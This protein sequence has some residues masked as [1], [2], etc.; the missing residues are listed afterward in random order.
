M[1]GYNYGHGPPR[2]QGGGYNQG[3]PRHQ[4]GYNQGPPRFGGGPPGPPPCPPPNRHPGRVTIQQKSMPIFFL[5]YANFF[6]SF[7]SGMIS[8]RKKRK[9][10]V[11]LSFFFQCGAIYDSFFKAIFLDFILYTQKEIR[12]KSI[13]KFNI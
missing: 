5:L 12:I 6:L 13:E 1:S 10:H 4:G 3:P 8:Y 7:K 2:H 11:L 9:D